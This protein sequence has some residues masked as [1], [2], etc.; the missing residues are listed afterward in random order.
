MDQPRDAEVSRHQLRHGDVLVFASDGLW[1]NLF[2]QDILRIVSRAMTETGAWAKT[3]AGIQ[4]VPDL[5]PFTKVDP[6]AA[7][8]AEERAKALSQRPLVVTLQSVLATEIVAAAKAASLNSSS[9]ARSRRRSR[10][11]ILTNHG[12]EARRMTSASWL[13][14]SRRRHRRRRELACRHLPGT[15]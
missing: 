8:Q 11:T 5:A 15:G 7:A 6:A 2:N 4:V 1:D 10:S 9:M 12:T 14:L 3:D 13:W